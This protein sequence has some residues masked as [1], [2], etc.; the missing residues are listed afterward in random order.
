MWTRTRAPSPSIWVNSAGSKPDTL[1]DVRNNP[2]VQQLNQKLGEQK[3]A[4]AQAL[5]VY[6]S[7]HPTAKKLQSEVDELQAQ[8]NSQKKAIVT[9]LRASYAAAEARRSL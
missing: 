5:V 7:N 2:V 9:S 4:L 6:G 1:A 8:I 3:A